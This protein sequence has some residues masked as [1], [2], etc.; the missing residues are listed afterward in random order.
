MGIHHGGGANT[1]STPTSPAALSGPVSAGQ[2]AS[3][4]GSQISLEELGSGIFI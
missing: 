3:C 2:P 4:A 1:L